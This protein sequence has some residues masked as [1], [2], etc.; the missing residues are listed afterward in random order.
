MKI[1]SHIHLWQFDQEEYD[2]IT[3]ELAAIRE[4]FTPD[5]LLPFHQELGID[6]FIAVQARQNHKENTFLLDYANKHNHVLG[7]VGWLDLQSKNLKKEIEELKKDPFLKGLRHILQSEPAGYMLQSKFIEGV[8]CLR[9]FDLTYDLL[10]FE[11]QLEEANTFMGKLHDDQK[12]VLDHIAKPKIKDA[13]LVD[14]KKGIKALA[15]HENLLCKVSGMVTEADW[16]NWQY[17]DFVPYMDVI[18]EEFGPDRILY[19]SD[20]PVCLLSSPYQSVFSILDQYLKPFDAAT[21]NKVMGD[22]A[23]AFY[24]V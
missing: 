4:S 21:R 17:D 5:D 2:W 8:K 23:A 24:K 12:V 3:D 19:G 14:W 9:E 20:W 15:K 11:N 7:V 6:G 18:F 10:I 16:Q 22:N 13:E 1:D